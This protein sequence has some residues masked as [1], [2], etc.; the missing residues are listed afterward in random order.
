MRGGG[1]GH[2]PG[3]PPRSPPRVQPPTPHSPTAHSPPPRTALHR[4]KR[5]VLAKTAA[6]APVS[7]S[8][9]PFLRQRGGMPRGQ[10]AASAVRNF[11]ATGAATVPP[12]RALLDEHGEA[13]RRPGSRRT[14]RAS[15][16][17]SSCRTPRCPVLPG[18]QRLPASP[19]AP[20]RSRP[21][22]TTANEVAQLVDHPRVE[23][24]GRAVAEPSGAGFVA[25]CR[26]RPWTPRATLATRAAIA[27]G[28]ARLRPCPMDADALSVWPLLSGTEPSKAPP[29]PRVLSHPVPRPR[30]GG[31]LAQLVVAELA[32]Q[33]D[34]CRVARV[35]EVRGEVR[36]PRATR[37]RSSCRTA[38]RRRGRLRARHRGGRGDVPAGEQRVARRRS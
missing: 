4:A 10:R 6:R 28:E 19:A 25:N 8:N 1:S 37:P 16:A 15:R 34:E 21:V 30:A 31:R 5:P 27:N 17:G 7:A 24:R 29:A 38:R 14:R 26:R 36:G 11:F 2:V 33:L 23:R 20:A 3:M 9:E 13:A 18:H 35:R 12:L 22:T 32:R